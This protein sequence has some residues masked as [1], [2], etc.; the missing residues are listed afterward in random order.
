MADLLAL[1]PALAEISV[2]SADGEETAHAPESTQ[3]N[4][5]DWTADP[6]YLALHDSANVLRGAGRR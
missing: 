3:R 1:N 5:P 4:P 6:A 2:V